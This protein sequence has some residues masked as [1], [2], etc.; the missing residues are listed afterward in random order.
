MTNIVADL[1]KNIKGCI[2]FYRDFLR[3]H[4]I[5]KEINQDIK[6]FNHPI[7]D[8]LIH[9]N[10]ARR[11]DD[12]TL[13]EL[14]LIN[15]NPLNMDLIKRL[16]RAF[17][18]TITVTGDSLEIDSS[19]HDKYILE[20]IL[21][22]LITDSACMT[23]AGLFMSITNHNDRCDYGINY[24]GVNICYRCYNRLAII[25]GYIEKYREKINGYMPLSDDEIIRRV[26]PWITFN[27]SCNEN[28]DIL[29][30]VFSKHNIITDTQ[31]EI[32][33]WLCI[34]ETRDNKK[35]CLDEI[36]Q[37]DHPLIMYNYLINRDVRPDN[38]IIGDYEGFYDRR[39]HEEKKCDFQ[40]PD[41]GWRK[42]TR[43]FNLETEEGIILYKEIFC[44]DTIKLCRDYV[45]Y[46]YNNV[47]SRN[48]C[49]NYDISRE[50]R[51]LSICNMCYKKVK[52]AEARIK[53]GGDNLND[54]YDYVDLL[55]FGSVPGY[56]FG[57]PMLYLE[58]EIEHKVGVCNCTDRRRNYYDCE[59]CLV[60]H[61][62]HESILLLA[63]ARQ[64]IRSRNTLARK[65]FVSRLLYNKRN[66]LPL[67]TVIEDYRPNSMYDDF[68]YL[69][70]DKL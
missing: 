44:N 21:E 59:E 30:R 42:I 68:K 39:N 55:R 28:H 7:F 5:K 17:G 27:I 33:H 65:I 32:K 1:P 38:N 31:K 23:Q 25:K 56:F 40:D 46:F 51:G 70:Q 50:Y 64:D 63:L 14:S 48:P 3:L 53:E 10:R 24:Y 2:S 13:C 15:Q 61:N 52:W 62:V 66:N 11:L 29:S 36:L 35:R 16:G 19:Y 22:R 49:F 26:Y 6:S 47:N 4:E 69:I 9:N 18:I 41:L 37:L 45:K 12:T 57:Q 60:K 43:P 8:K 54:T 58:G 20:N 34:A 67:N